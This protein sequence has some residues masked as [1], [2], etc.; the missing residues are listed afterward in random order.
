[1]RGALR[2]APRAARGA[3]A[4]SLAGKRHQ[5]LVGAISAAVDARINVIN[6][7]LKT[8]NDNLLALQKE[9]DNDTRMNRKIQDSLQEDLQDAQARLTKLLQ[10]LE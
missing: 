9:A 7:Y 1:V 8:A 5:L 2:H 10:D 4:A 3:K 6:S